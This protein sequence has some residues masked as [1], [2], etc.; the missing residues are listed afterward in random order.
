M[1]NTHNVIEDEWKGNIFAVSSKLQK[2]LTIQH[3]LKK[4][5]QNL[6][7]PPNILEIYLKC[8]KMF[9]VG[10]VSV[11]CLCIAF[12]ISWFPL[13]QKYQKNTCDIFIIQ[14][15][16]HRFQSDMWENIYFYP[17]PNLKK[18]HIWKAQVKCYFL[19]HVSFVSLY[20]L[21]M[22]FVTITMHFIPTG[23]PEFVF[24]I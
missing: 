7:I 9:M 20:G 5:L 2:S 16:S 8:L 10:K 4:E 14:F 11:K 3:V 1:R 17:I 12:S 21:S 22:T 6:N 15:F 18:F 23:V 24:W 19:L 13:N